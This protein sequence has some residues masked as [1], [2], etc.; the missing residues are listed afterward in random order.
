MHELLL[1]KLKS[2]PYCREALRWLDEL[3]AE[4]PAYAAISIRQ[5]DEREEKDL[6]DSYDYYYV[7]AFFLNG[8]KLHEGAAT[9]E[10]IKHVL[11]TCLRSPALR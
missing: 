5:I 3:I 8:Q 2:C 10:K 1:F 7:P 6:A 11:D 9:K 4:N